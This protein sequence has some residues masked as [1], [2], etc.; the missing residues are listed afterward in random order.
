MLTVSTRIQALHSNTVIVG[1]E[2]YRYN[3]SFEEP[4]GPYMAL[5]L[6]HATVSIWNV[7][8]RGRE[9]LVSGAVPVV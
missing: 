4:H 3:L 6:W 5:N 9:R 2:A 7:L 8:Y 1:E